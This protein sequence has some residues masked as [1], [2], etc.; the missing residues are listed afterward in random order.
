MTQ[1][2]QH[3]SLEELIYSDTALRLQINNDPPPIVLENLIYTASQL[4][5]VRNI[6]N[7]NSIN[8]TSGYR[9]LSL[10]MSIGSKSTSQ[11]ITGEAVDFK[12]PQFG[13]PR[14]IIQAL[15]YS[16]LIFDQLI[17]EF[18]SWVHVSFVKQNNRHQV[19]VI[20]KTG[21]RLFN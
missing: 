15:R 19:L 6:L 4:E 8:I 7:N 1:L 2:S 17:L 9:C 10:N 13:P 14:L 5:L 18:D 3:F 16:N 12:C 20:D 21:T 11:H